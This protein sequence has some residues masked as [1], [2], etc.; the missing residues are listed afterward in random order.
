MKWEVKRKGEQ[1]AI[2]L[3]QKYCNTDEPV[4]YGV[5]AS[6]AGADLCAYR[7]NNPLT[8]KVKHENNG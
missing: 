3:I 6:K 5:S 2:Y 4:C 7:L 1:W 8:G